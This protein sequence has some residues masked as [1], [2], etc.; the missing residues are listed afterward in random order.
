MHMDPEFNCLEKIITGMDLNG[1]AARDH[2][3]KM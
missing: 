1:M 2:V 3:P